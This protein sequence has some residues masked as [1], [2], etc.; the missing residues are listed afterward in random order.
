[1]GLLGEAWKEHQRKTISTFRQG[2]KNPSVSCYSAKQKWLYSLF[3]M[4]IKREGIT[5]IYGDRSGNAELCWSTVFVT[6]KEKAYPLREV[7]SKAK[8]SRSRKYPNLSL[9]G[10]GCVCVSLCWGGGGVY[11][12]WGLVFGLCTFLRLSLVTFTRR[13]YWMI[14]RGP[15]FLAVLWYAQP[16]FSATHQKSGKRSKRPSTVIYTRW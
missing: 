13:K 9:Y 10:S 14:Y 15:G 11:R 6:I 16:L 7:E 2:E 4:M 3:H 8:A 1:M 5:L 12:E